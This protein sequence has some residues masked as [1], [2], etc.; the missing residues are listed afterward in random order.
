MTFRRTCAR[1]WGERSDRRRPSDRQVLDRHRALAEAVADCRNSRARGSAIGW[2]I[3]P[4][5]FFHAYLP[6]Y[7]FW[8]SIVAGSLAVLMLQYV[9]GGEWGLMIRRPLGAAARTMIW[10]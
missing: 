4:E 9:S 7:L 10:M 8:F 1:S 2:F 5:E 6:S 3:N